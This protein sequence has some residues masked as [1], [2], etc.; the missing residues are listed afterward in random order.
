[1]EKIAVD[2]NLVRQANANTAIV[3]SL[4][5]Q[6]IKSRY[7]IAYMLGISHNTVNNCKKRLND[8]NNIAGANSDRA[9]SSK[10]D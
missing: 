5:D 8:Y 3:K 2:L 1:M 9:T 6:G 4:L 10:R 7:Q